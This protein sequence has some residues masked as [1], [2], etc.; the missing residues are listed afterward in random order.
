MPNSTPPVHGP[1]AARLREPKESKHTVRPPKNVAY[2]PS[3]AVI[4]IDAPIKECPPSSCATRQVQEKSAQAAH[5]AA[6]ISGN[7]L[8]KGL[9]REKKCLF[10][11]AKLLERQKVAE[12][13]PSTVSIIMAARSEFNFFPS[14]L[15]VTEARSIYKEQHPQII[16]DE[17]SSRSRV[18]QPCALQYGGL[19]N[20]S[21]VVHDLQPR[22]ATPWHDV[23]SGNVNQPNQA[24]RVQDPPPG[25]CRLTL[26]FGSYKISVQ[27]PLT[28][29]LGQIVQSARSILGGE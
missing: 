7:S 2:S 12:R 13:L 26:E 4:I 15:E 25:V 5:N 29:E 18:L 17:S 16:D 3:D 10:I 24:E 27:G 23:K 22:S 8:P 19:S 21:A 1:A 6:P 28:Q 14:R 11:I 9:S 20:Q